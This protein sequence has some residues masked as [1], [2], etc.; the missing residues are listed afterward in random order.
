V[1]CTWCMIQKARR[2]RIVN[3]VVSGL[4]TVQL[5][6]CRSGWLSHARSLFRGGH[7][8]HLLLFASVCQRFGNTAVQKTWSAHASSASLLGS[9]AYSTVQ[10]QTKVST[11]S[12]ELESSRSQLVAVQVRCAAALHARRPA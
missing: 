11:L 9:M 8:L 5:N 10:L 6:D 3:Y 2:I 7:R 4:A 1:T 12:R